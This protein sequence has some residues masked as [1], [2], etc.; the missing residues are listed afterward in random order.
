[1]IPEPN[2]KRRFMGKMMLMDKFFAE[3]RIETPDHKTFVK[4]VE[5]GLRGYVFVRKGDSHKELLTVFDFAYLFGH[6]S[7]WKKITDIPTISDFKACYSTDEKSSVFSTVY[8]VVKIF[9]YAEKQCPEG[10]CIKLT[11][12]NNIPWVVYRIGGFK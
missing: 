5:S 10:L 7:Y 11:G 1:M 8:R 2:W 9:N 3:D 6:P 12:K 4:V